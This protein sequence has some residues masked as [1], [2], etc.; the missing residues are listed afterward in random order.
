MEVAR[1]LQKQ[2]GHC[3][4]GPVATRG[5]TRWKDVAPLAHRVNRGGL[6]I[7][8]NGNNGVVPKEYSLVRA[9]QRQ[10]ICLADGRQRN[11]SLRGSLPP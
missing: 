11:I 8:V 10:Q 5:P 6:N 9:C 2:Q 1:S 4:G 7:D 3:R